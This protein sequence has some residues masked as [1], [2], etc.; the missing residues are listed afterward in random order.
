[1]YLWSPLSILTLRL[2]SSFR[3]TRESMLQTD[4]LYGLKFSNIPLINLRME[5]NRCFLFVFD[6]LEKALS[7]RIAPI[8][9]PLMVWLGMPQDLMTLLI[10]RA[11][12]GIEAYIPGAVFYETGIRGKLTSE[13]AAKLKN[14]FAFGARN[15][16]GNFYHH[17]P[18]QADPSFSLRVVD[19]QL[20]DRTVR[21]Y[22][23]IRNP[24]F[25]GK[26]LTECTVGPVRNT[27]DHLAQLYEWIDSWHPPER[28]IKGGAAFENVRARIAHSK[29][30]QRAAKKSRSH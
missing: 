15:S 27:F 4:D 6:G 21:F 18:A 30:I 26:Q 13:L 29:G 10:Q 5:F 3:S 22:N 8:E 7:S 28:L 19:K 12:L 9:T 17:L 25:H 2:N 16:V 24:L 23:Q 1:M 11:V 14:P 20:Y